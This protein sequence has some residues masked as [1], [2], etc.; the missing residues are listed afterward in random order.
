MAAD[1]KNVTLPNLRG[2][3]FQEKKKKKKKKKKGEK[4][5]RWGKGNPLDYD[6]KDTFCYAAQGHTRN[7]RRKK[8]GPAG[9]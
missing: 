1:T 8:R 9:G 5:N 7:S 2:A 6:P 3:R 4:E